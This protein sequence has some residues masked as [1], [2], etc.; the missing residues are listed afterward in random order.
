MSNSW[1]IITWVIILGSSLVMLLWIVL[2]SFFESFDFAHEAQRL[3]GGVT[4]WV[5]VGLAVA[6][7]LRE[8]TNSQTSRTPNSNPQFRACL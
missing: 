3:C 2:Y 4:F 7:A 5:T 6:I 1:T 8:S